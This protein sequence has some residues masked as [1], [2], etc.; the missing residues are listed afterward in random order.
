MLYWVFVAFVIYLAV[1]IIVKILSN[2]KNNGVNNYFFSK[3]NLSGYVAALSTQASD[4]SSWLLMSLPGAIY[5]FGTNQAWIAI[6]LFVG[7]VCNWIFVAG[8]LRRYTI[9][10]GNA[11]TIPEYLS[12]RFRDN[13]NILRTI[14]A[15]VIVI[16]FS[17]YIASAFLACGKLVGVVL[18]FEYKVSLIIGVVVILIYSLIGGFIAICYTDFIQ[19]IL[20]LVGILAVPITAVFIMGIE[21]VIPN[22]VDSGVSVSATNYL[23]VFKKNGDRISAID[24]I[25]KLAWGLGYAGMPH[26]LVRFMAIKDE[27]ELVKSKKIAVS[28][29][30]IALSVAC[31]IGVIGRAYLFPTVLGVNEN[32]LETENVFIEMI[33]KLFMNDLGIPF[34]GG[35]FLCIILAAIISTADSQFL[36]ISSSVAKDFGKGVI[37]KKMSHMSVVLVGKVSVIVIAIISCMIALKT[38]SSIMGLVSI[39]WAGFGSAFGPVII[40]S[41]YWKRTNAYGVA[42]GMIN[43]GLTVFIWEYLKIIT[44]QD[45]IRVTLSERTGV[46]S[47]LVG[48]IVG[49]L[50][51]IITTL[52]TKKVSSE[53]LQEFD[54]VKNRLD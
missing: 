33:I 29:V 24:I 9:K 18:G 17:V 36:V 11:M 1:M 32:V 47:L 31:L 16:F 4:M 20:I 28:W 38:N 37:F 42:A 2:K 53:I 19:G 49:L 41:L 44:N 27:K 21:N 14:A 10:A 3:R 45:G 15:V 12:N 22:L 25:S 46:Y 23:D 7:T 35:L 8:R 26:I 39:A 5:A 30:F 43:G 50:S 40:L 48:F 54:D 51:S 13:K 34:L 6:G 52:C